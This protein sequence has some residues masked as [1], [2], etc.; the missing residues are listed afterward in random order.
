MRINFPAEQALKVLHRGMVITQGEYA[1]D[2][3]GFIHDL[4]WNFYD[5]IHR[6][7]VHNIGYNKPS[8]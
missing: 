5:E 2:V 7:Y 6:I 3:P 1:S 8:I 4:D